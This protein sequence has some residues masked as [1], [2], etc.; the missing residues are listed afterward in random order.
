MIVYLSL[1]VLTA[2]LVIVV[3]LSVTYM[4]Y[5]ALSMAWQEEVVVNVEVISKTGTFRFRC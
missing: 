5:P 4:F 1:E 2:L 3:S